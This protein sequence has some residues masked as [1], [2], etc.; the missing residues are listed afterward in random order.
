VGSTPASGTI[1][2][3][4]TAFDIGNLVY[5]FDN[6]RLYGQLDE[7]SLWS[8]ALSPQ[9]ISCM[10][11]NGIDASSPGLELYYDFNQGIAGGNNIGITSLINQ[12]GSAN[13]ILNGFALNGLTS[14]FVGGVTSFIT[15]DSATICSGDSYTF[16][17][18]TLT[19]AGNYT[20]AFVSASGCDSI[21][22]LQLNVNTIDTTITQI[23][24][25]LTSNQAGATYQ[26]LDCNAG[27]AAIPG[28][29]LQTLNPLVD[30]SYAVAVTLNGCTDTSGCIVIVGVGLSEAEQSMAVSAYPNP[31][32]D[33]INLNL[34]EKGNI[35]ITDLAGRVI[36]NYPEM[37][38]GVNTLNLSRFTEG[39]YFISYT[40]ENRKATIRIIKK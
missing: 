38:S 22:E 18:Q 6:F 8:I 16:G 1:A 4:A 24:F 5:S 34:P 39:I 26:W 15:Q 36:G 30:G 2:T 32:T 23:D 21:V 20:E 40:S 7:V 27:Y 29:T 25:S 31:V 12:T 33:L 17:T 3:S 19:T 10:Y 11:S 35:E 28:D 13:G 14:N 9:E 37:N